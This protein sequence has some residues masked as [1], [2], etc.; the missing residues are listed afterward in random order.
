MKKTLYA[1]ILIT[2]VSLTLTACTKKSDNQGLTGEGNGNEVAMNEEEESYNTSLLDLVKMGKSVKCTYEYSDEE[3]SSSGTTYVS[4]EKTRSE[5]II[6]TADG[7]EET[8]YTITDGNT[9]Y[10]WSAKDKQGIKMSVPEE[11]HE[12]DLDIPE[13]GETYQYNDQTLKMDY[14]CKPWIPDNSKFVAPSDVEFTDYD[15]IVKDMM[16]M[17]EQMNI[18]IE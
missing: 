8:A 12:Q 1:I 9:M 7:E 6:K 3:A 5:S 16:E 11:D 15:Q 14:K 4:G 13:A 2:L 18:P 10:F 17:S